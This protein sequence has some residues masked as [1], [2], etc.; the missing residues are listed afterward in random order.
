MKL[1]VPG[2]NLESGSVT[3][4]ERLLASDLCVIAAW[5]HRFTVLWSN[6]MRATQK[7]NRLQSAPS[8]REIQMKD[9]NGGYE[10]IRDKL[11]AQRIAAKNCP[12]FNCKI[13]L[14]DDLKFE[15]NNVAEHETDDRAHALNLASNLV[16]GSLRK[17]EEEY[18]HCQ[19][20][21]CNIIS[22]SYH[23][24][25]CRMRAIQYAGDKIEFESGF[26][27]FGK[28]ANSAMKSGD[29]NLYEKALRKLGVFIAEKASGANGIGE[30]LSNMP[31][32]CSEKINGEFHSGK[33]GI[34]FL[35]NSLSES[36]LPG[37][38]SSCGE[39][40]ANSYS[41]DLS[42]EWSD[43][44]R[45]E[46]GHFAAAEGLHQVRLIKEP[47]ET[48]GPRSRKEVRNLRKPK[49]IISQVKYEVNAEKKSQN[50]L[51]SKKNFEQYKKFDRKIDGE[52]VS[53]ISEVNAY[54]MQE[55]SNAKRRMKEAQFTGE[56]IKNV[57]Y[58]NAGGAAGKVPPSAKRDRYCSPLDS[59]APELKTTHRA[60][61]DFGREAIDWRDLVGR[62]VRRDRFN[63]Q[64]LHNM[65]RLL[66]A[67]CEGVSRYSRVRH[68]QD[69]L[70]VMKRYFEE[71][72]LVFSSEEKYQKSADFK[73]AALAFSKRC[74]SYAKL[75]V[76]YSKYKPKQAS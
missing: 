36:N 5:G 24:L 76:K 31:D 26:D 40:M 41:E 19:H 30:L 3:Q 66:A 43:K 37:P 35:E 58:G 12:T 4:G 16:D 69:D 67:D 10:S 23:S 47:E 70:S 64:L 27:C 62:E 20:D 15:L 32:E 28:A 13:Q 14:T 22:R 55:K 61:E 74:E 48:L 25:Y 68:K 52:T 53:E 18:Q 54:K 57:I 11:G 21:D 71:Q 7:A 75:I 33:E 29:M 17:F 60:R 34:Y 65:C 1:F 63:I 50:H 49:K 42:P 9:R 39:D 45:N 59:A 56:S 46:L 51:T 73:G 38:E 2:W 8:I 72:A 44:Q 6:F